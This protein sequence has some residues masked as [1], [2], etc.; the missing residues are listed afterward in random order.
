MTAQSDHL[1]L[2]RS[3]VIEIDGVSSLTAKAVV[4]AVD[5]FDGGK[6]C[7]ASVST[8]SR[9]AG[10][11][12]RSTQRAIK[13]LVRAGVLRMEKHGGIKGSAGGK[14]THRYFVVWSEVEKYKPQGVTLSPSDSDVV[15]PSDTSQ[16]DMVSRDGDMVSPPKVTWCRS[17][18]D[19]VSPKT[20]EKRNMETQRNIGGSLS[21]KRPTP[22]N[23]P[24]A[25]QA[26]LDQVETQ[27]KATA[28]RQAQR[29]AGIKS[30]RFLLQNRQVTNPDDW[31]K[32]AEAAFEYAK[33]KTGRSEFC[34]ALT[35]F[36]KGE[37]EEDPETWGGN[38]TVR[39]P[40]DQLKPV[41]FEWDADKE[42]GDEQ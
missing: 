9:S 18:G 23:D 16:G 10:A 17:D 24:D 13:V 14:A 19:M 28:G 31:F 29:G 32:P 4:R 42:N 22:I 36:C 39:T 37:W 6:G 30:L 26:C 27:W 8:I 15:S 3:V 20:Q 2:M 34:M 7:Y 41:E 12:K 21:P 1:I 11:S 25:I 5:D 33:S 40:V 38:G 35:R